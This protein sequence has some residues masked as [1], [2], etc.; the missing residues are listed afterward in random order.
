MTKPFSQDVHSAKLLAESHCIYEGTKNNG[1]ARDYLSLSNVS[2]VRRCLQ[3]G[4]VL[5]ARACTPCSKDA[6]DGNYI[7]FS[8]VP[9]RSSKRVNGCNGYFGSTSF[10]SFSSSSLRGFPGLVHQTM[11]ISSDRATP[12]S[13]SS[14][15]MISRLLYIYE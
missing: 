14:I 6:F 10:L 15:H 9:C 5:S 12:A 4:G 2:A 8:S 13:R 1:R 3:D 7:Y 11:R